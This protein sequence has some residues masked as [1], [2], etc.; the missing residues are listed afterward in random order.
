MIPTPTSQVASPP[1]VTLANDVE[2][3]IVGLREMLSPYADR[4][5]LIEGVDRDM[6]TEGCDIVLFDATTADESSLERLER[7]IADP[8]LGKVVIYTWDVDG[9]FAE[10]GRVAGV[11]AVVSKSA[12]AAEL[13]ELLEQVHVGEW[14]VVVDDERPRLDDPIAT[15]TGRE[16]Q[17]LGILAAGR[18]NKEIADD[19]FVSPE[20][21]KSHVRSI[22]VKLGARNRTEAARMALQRA[23]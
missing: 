14:T 12:T 2:L 23:R 13:V 17:V 1:R 15:L 21:V 6:P 4:I 16:Q 5:S 22:L 20:T 9:W 10:Q 7:M 18:S 19:L 11:D 8:S 3:V